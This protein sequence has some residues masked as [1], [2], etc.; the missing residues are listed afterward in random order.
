MSVIIIRIAHTKRGN[1]IDY[2]KNFVTYFKILYRKYK[3][4]RAYKM[5]FYVTL[6]G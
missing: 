6:L 1:Y 5:P 4:N 3:H 2:E